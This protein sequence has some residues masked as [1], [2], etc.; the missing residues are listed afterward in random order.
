MGRKRKEKDGIFDR[1]G[2]EVNLEKCPE[3][4]EHPDCFCH[5]NGKCTAL[6][7][8]GGQGGVFYK[9]LEQALEESR[10]VYR[11]LKRI[12]RYDLIQRYI[13]VYMAMGIL[14]DEIEAETEKIKEIEAF[15]HMD[16]QMLITQ[17][18]GF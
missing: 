1:I 4:S 12:K 11:K 8:S 10:M 5:L 17:I 2:E 15:R 7:A 9:P 16:L 6:N 14:D 18:P 13:K 3:C